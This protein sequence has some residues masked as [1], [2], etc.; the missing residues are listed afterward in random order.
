MPIMRCHTTKQVERAQNMYRYT[1]SEASSIALRQV[2][3][4]ASRLALILLDACAKKMNT[5]FYIAHYIPLDNGCYPKQVTADLCRR[6]RLQV[7]SWIC[8]GT[9][10]SGIPQSRAANVLSETRRFRSRPCLGSQRPGSWQ[11][12]TPNLMLG[13]PIFLRAWQELVA[14]PLASK[15]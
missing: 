11:A 8:T 7:R 13:Q 15:T 4:R 10:R 1:T 5:C 2:A 3:L 12:D 9:K 14:S 6:G